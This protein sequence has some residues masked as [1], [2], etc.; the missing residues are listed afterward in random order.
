MMA[1]FAKG[2][3]DNTHLVTDQLSKSFDFSGTIEMGYGYIPDSSV[4]NNN[5]VRVG[6]T[7]INVYGAP[8]QDMNELADIIDD[9]INAKYANVRAA[10]A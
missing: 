4:T 2:I 5:S 1:L 3:K 6:D 8:G 9:K 7:V 10:W